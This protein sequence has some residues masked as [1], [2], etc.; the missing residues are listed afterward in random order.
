M[1]KYWFSVTGL[2]STNKTVVRRDPRKQKGT[3][4]RLIPRVS[5]GLR[6]DSDDGSTP[7]WQ[8]GGVV[9][10]KRCAESDAIAQAKS[11]V[12][13]KILACSQ[14]LFEALE[15]LTIEELEQFR[16]CVTEGILEVFVPIPEE[17]LPNGCVDIA[18]RLMEIYGIEGSLTVTVHILNTINRDDLGKRLSSEVD[19]LQTE[20]KEYP[21]MDIC[22]VKGA[23][24][25]DWMT[26][27]VAQYACMLTL[28][29]QTAHPNLRLS[30][31]DTKATFMS[32]K[33]L[34]SDHLERF[35]L[36]PQVMC[37]EGLS[38]GRFCWEVRWGGYAAIG[39]AYKSIARKGRGDECGL[40]FTKKSW[41]LL[42]EVKTYS[43]WHDAKPIRLSEE[44]A[45]SRR[46]RVC[47]DW[48]AGALTFYKVAQ[49]ALIHLHTFHAAFSEPL[50]PMFRFYYFGQF[51]SSVTLEF[52]GIAMCV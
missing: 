51:G 8:K 6:V 12:E 29:S 38:Y 17:L 19:R 42:C 3:E 14:C 30:G 28:D 46:I 21:M 11:Q 44:P 23:D 49:D 18:E 20:P 34:H 43:A 39:V 35:N 15:E 1:M 9:D 5:L 7:A 33:Q 16:L 4:L 32:K 22:I 45:S 52:P 26:G 25:D 24:D 36:W 10:K 31:A 2:L 37:R 13:L 41:C 27:D 50:H 48:Y 47:L 40:G